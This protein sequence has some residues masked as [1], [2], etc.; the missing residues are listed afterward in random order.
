MTI[1]DTNVLSALMHR[2]PDPRVIAWLDVQPRTSMWITAITALEVRFGLQIMPGGKRRVA[3]MEAF[4]KVLDTLEQR[5][6]AFDSAAARHAADLMAIRHQ[7]GRPV[8]LRDTMIAGIA[9]AQHAA[10]ATRN[11]SHFD[12][13]SL[14]LIN[15]WA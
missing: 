1:L 3:L 14:T 15:P 13:T 10:V 4:E 6:L 9:L 12:D 8:E 7:K 2:N 11:T 5:V